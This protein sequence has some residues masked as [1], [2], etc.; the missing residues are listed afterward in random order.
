[1]EWLNPLGIREAK[2]KAALIEIEEDIKTFL[3]ERDPTVKL[4]ETVKESDPQSTLWILTRK[5]SILRL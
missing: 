4:T 3:C 2:L 5:K 1:M